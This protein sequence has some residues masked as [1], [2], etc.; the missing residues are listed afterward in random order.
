[1]KVFL[2]AL[3]F[4]LSSFHAMALDQTLLDLS[5]EPPVVNTSPGPEYDDAA[6]PGNMIIGIDRTP[7]GRLWA[8][9][10]GNGDS[11]NGF[12]MLATSDDGGAKWSKPRVVIDPSDGTHESNGT[13][14]AYTRRALVGNLWTDPLGRLWCFFDQSLGYF[15]GRCGDWYIRCDDPDTAEPVWTKPLRF[16]DGCT[17][18]KPFV[19]PHQR[20][21]V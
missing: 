18:N 11:P 9:W 6:R 15:D 10:V 21:L 1:M 2:C 20:R 5:L 4:V 16:A 17:L 13:K 14:T 7:K 19:V 8:A 3:I 12:F